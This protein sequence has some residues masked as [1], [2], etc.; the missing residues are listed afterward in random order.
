MLTKIRPSTV[1][2]IKQLASKIKRE[3][4]ITHT[5]ALD[6]AS[7]QAGFESFV[8]ARRQLDKQAMSYPVYLSVY[9]RSKREKVA[10]GEPWAGREFLRVNL[11]RPLTEVIAKH[12]VHLARGLEQFRQEYIDHLERITDVASCADAH[13]VL[14]AAQ[15]S[16]RFM[17]ATGL[18]PA[19]TQSL[20]DI[21]RKLRDV[22]HRDHTSDWCNPGSE[23]VV[24][25]DEPYSR[26][27]LDWHEARAQWARAN[28]V[29]LVSPQ[30]E[31]I[32]FPGQCA[33]FLLSR[34][35]VELKRLTVALE[36]LPPQ[37]VP[38][39]WP[40][41]TGRYSEDF[42]SPLRTADSRP[43][44]PR[45]GPSYQ[46]HMGSTP[47]GGRP[48]IPSKRKP[49]QAMPVASHQRLGEL[50]QSIVH[51]GWSNRVYDKLSIFR[52]NLEEWMFVEHGSNATDNVYY[53]GPSAR[54]LEGVE[55]LAPA[56]AQ[57]TGIIEK[58]YNDCKP[59]KELLAALALASTELGQR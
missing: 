7:R 43:R 39:T 11:S 5:T 29:G 3:K 26:S 13:H 10:P 35:Q 51:S 6:L 19:S 21:A 30:W 45:P 34:D 23:A 41:P 36:A 37:A 31:G 4:N 47:Y 32:Y 14:L 58:G 17:D 52:S 12:R 54:I 25:L 46:D 28:D 57:V 40:H 1:D 48:G 15:R 24:V 2:G 8:H 59:R 38:T 22:P 49:S 44:R 33:P 50:L 56:L 20:H 9:W 27:V 42:I 16:L 18:Q 53:G 55:E